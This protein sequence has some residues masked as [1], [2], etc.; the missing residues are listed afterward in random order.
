VRGAIRLNQGPLPELGVL[1]A[2]LLHLLRKRKG[3]RAGV[4]RERGREGGGREGEVGRG[5]GGGKG[6]ERADARYSSGLAA[7]AVYIK[8]QA[9]TGWTAGGGEMDT[10][11]ALPEIRLG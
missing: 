10:N 2:D 7:A 4:G 6:K 9:G 5:K 1:L 8:A 11:S 3:V